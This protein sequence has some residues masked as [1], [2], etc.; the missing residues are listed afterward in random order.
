MNW[1]ALSAYAAGGLT[2]AVAGWLAARRFPR[3]RFELRTGLFAAG[4]LLA[5]ALLAGALPMAVNPASAIRITA[6]TFT[7]VNAVCRA[8]PC[9]TPT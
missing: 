4:V 1:I 7:T 8:V 2:G 5:G 6:A 9:R 3:W